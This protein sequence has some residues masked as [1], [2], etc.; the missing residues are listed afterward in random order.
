MIKDDKKENKTK[1]KTKITK[2]NEYAVY[3]YIYIYIHGLCL[4]T[5]GKASMD[6][7]W[8]LYTSASIHHSD[9]PIFPSYLRI[10]HLSMYSEPRSPTPRSCL[11]EVY[12]HRRQS[13]M[14]QFR[15]GTM[16]LLVLSKRTPAPTRKVTSYENNGRN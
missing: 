5:R 16:K 11:G 15:H 14:T 6:D 2:N 13:V 7:D 9:D 3:I 10:H 4:P 1:N 12:R 8:R